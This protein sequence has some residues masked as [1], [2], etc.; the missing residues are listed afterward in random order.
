MNVVCSF[1]ITLKKQRAGFGLL[2]CLI[3]LVIL[4]TS[5]LMVMNVCLL[6]IQQARESLILNQLDQQV[7]SLCLF[8]YQ[9][10]QNANTI[11]AN[12]QNQFAIL[13]PDAKSQIQYTTNQTIIEIHIHSYTLKVLAHGMR[14]QKTLTRH[15]AG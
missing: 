8:L 1:S 7:D 13:F 9:H 10:E 2:E 14:I 15:D 3:T 5:V 12:W 11:I 6:Q 4:S